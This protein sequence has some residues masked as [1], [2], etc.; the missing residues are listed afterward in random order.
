[1]EPETSTTSL[2]QDIIHDDSAEILDFV[3]MMHKERI[4]SEIRERNQEKKL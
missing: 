2:R 1:M 4:S 3:E